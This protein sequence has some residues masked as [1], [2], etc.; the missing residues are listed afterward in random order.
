MSGNDRGRGDGRERRRVDP[1]ARAEWR[2]ERQKRG[3]DRFLLFTDAVVA[4]AITLLILPVVERASDITG[5]DLTIS[6]IFRESGTQIYGFLLSFVVIAVMW[7]R[8]QEIFQNVETINRSLV[9]VNLGW[10]LTVIALA[11]TTALTALHGSDSIAAPIYIA[12]V[13]L[14]SLMLTCSV[15][16]LSRK[17]ELLYPDT[18]P[19]AV[20]VRGSWIATGLLALAVVVVLLVPPVSYYAMFL[21]FLQRPL[22]LRL[23]P[24]EEWQDDWD[25]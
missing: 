16:I 9:W 11:F 4:I 18:P 6:A 24:K 14:N 2:R 21:L 13:A 22:M 15:T 20:H 19:H 3:F 8:H 1:E 25:A 17:P 12:N 7:L 23:V 5:D 10:L